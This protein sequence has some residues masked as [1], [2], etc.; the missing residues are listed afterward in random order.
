MAR[1]VRGCPKP[2]SQQGGT[3]EPET[4]TGV[5]QQE[6]KKE[7]T[8][9]KVVAD[10]DPDIDNK[11][12][13]SDPEIKAVNEEEE[14]SDAEYVKMELSQTRTLYQRTMNHKVAKRIELAH[15]A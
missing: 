3:D 2:W 7:A 11:P 14:H 1:P 4:S 5:P 9:G 8:R 15:W 10:Y 13:E 12:E 6:G